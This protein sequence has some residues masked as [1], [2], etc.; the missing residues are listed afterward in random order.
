MAQGRQ[1]PFTREAARLKRE[2]EINR[3][4]ETAG[5]HAESN[6][7][8]QHEHQPRHHPANAFLDAFLNA[9]TDNDHGQ[10][11]DQGTPATQR[12]GVSV[13]GTK[14]GRHLVHTGARQAAGEHF[15]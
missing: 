11:R 1:H 3:V 6:Q 7:Q 2:Q 15:P 8:H 9:F 5:K 12:D 13:I 4:A 10:Q 14:H